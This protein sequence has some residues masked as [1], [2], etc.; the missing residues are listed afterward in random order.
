ANDGYAVSSI[1]GEDKSAQRSQLSEKDAPY[2]MP[3]LHG[4][5]AIPWFDQPA[6]CWMPHIVPNSLRPIDPL[7]IK[8]LHFKSGPMDE[9]LVSAVKELLDFADRLYGDH[10]EDG[11]GGRKFI[12]INEMGQKFFRNGKSGENI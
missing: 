12:D 7:L 5:P 10:N 11:I 3:A 2:V 6:A 9:S 1:T 4:D 8:P